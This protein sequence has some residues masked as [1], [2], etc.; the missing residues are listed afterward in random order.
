MIFPMVQFG[1]VIPERWVMDTIEAI[2]QRR[3]IRGYQSRDVARETVEAILFDAAQ[4]PTPPIS[5][6][7]PFVFI[8]IEGAGRVEEY[9]AQAL[10]FARTHRKP[11]PAYDWVDR[12]DFSVFFNA[13]MAVIICGFEDEHGQALQDCNR[14]GQ[15]LMLSAH[16]RG[17]GT[18]WVGSPMQW[19]HDPATQA[20]L[21]VPRNYAPHAAFALG[22]PATVPQGAPRAAPEVIWVT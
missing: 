16:A 8:V 13:P 2:H 9:G 3:S 12:P 19:L 1:H 11:G 22:Y 17:L 20:L 14:A 6:K 21:G 4:A 5:S 10:S 7:A 18:C 15:N